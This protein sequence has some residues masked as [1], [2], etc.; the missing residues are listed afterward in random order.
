MKIVYIDDDPD[1]REIFCYAI[2]AVDSGISCLDFE[3]G[4][5]ALDYLLAN[6]TMPDFI[7]IDINM[8]RMNGYE[9][10][11]KIKAAKNLK[12]SQIVMY[13]TAFQPKDLIEFTKLGIKFLNKPTSFVNL[14]QSIKSMIL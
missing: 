7:F 3:S 8:P 12:K 2:K 14:V 1:D 10:A 4:T 5:K 6:P 9:C 13:S 11:Q